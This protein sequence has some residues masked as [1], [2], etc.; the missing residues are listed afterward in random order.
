MK[1]W[2]TRWKVEPWKWRGLP[3]LPT[4]FSPVQ[5]AR[6]F[7]AVYVV[8]VSAGSNGKFRMAGQ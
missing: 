7:S 4:P 8:E 5:R 3:D 2:I 1:F 6:K